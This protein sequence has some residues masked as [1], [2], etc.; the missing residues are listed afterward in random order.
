MDEPLIE[1]L[2]EASRR[3]TPP[4]EGELRVEGLTGAVEVIR[5]RWGVPHIYARELRDLYFAQGLV[6]GS[7]RLF[8]LDL[9]FRLG[10]GR[11]SELLGSLGLPFDRFARTVGWNRAARRAVE[12]YDDLSLDT[13]EAFAAGVRAW[14]ERM[15]APPVEYR[16][17]DLEP[18]H[19]DEGEA[20]FVG[21]SAAAFMAWGLSRNWDNELLRAEI[22]ER[23]GVEVM[24]TLFPDL[25]PESAV[26]TA[27]EGPDPLSLLT[28]APLPPSGQGSNNWVVSGSRT[29]TGKP[30]LANDPHLLVQ[31]PSIWFECHLVGPGIDVAGVSLPFSPGVVIGHND[32]IAWGFTNTEGD[33]QDLYL[34]RLS[35]DGRRAEFEGSWEPLR[36]HREEIRVR[37]LDQPEMVEVMESR[38][39]PLLDSYLVGVSEPTVV[40]GGIGRS[41]ALRWA[42]AEALIQPSTIH[43]MNAARNWEEFRQ[44]VRGWTCPGQNMVYADVDGNIGYQAT[45]LYP[46]RGNGDG[47]MP[48]PGWTGRHEWEGWIPFDELPRAFNP[49]RG[50]LLTANNKVY[51]DAYPHN[52]GRDFLPPHRARRIAELLTESDR[53]DRTSF[54][55]IQRDT[56][57]L[58]ARRLVPLLLR[59]EPGTDRHKQAMALLTEW[60]H[61]LGAGSAAAALY[62]VWVKHIAMRVLPPVLQDEALYTH[63]Y[64]RRQ[65]TNAFHHLVLP[66]LL[67]YPTAR[68]FGRDGVEARDEVLR[69]SLDD[70]LDELTA[71]LGEDMAEWRWGALHRVRFAGP[72]ARIPDLAPLFTAA[73]VEVGGDEQTVNQAMFEPG[74][75]YDA[76]VVPSWRQILDPS[77]WDASVGTHTTG[78]SGHPASPHYADLV[79]LW[80]AGEHHPMPFSRRAVEDAAEGTL[81]LLPS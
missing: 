57:S 13:A 26:V 79:E 54:A 76:M 80:A 53:H 75:S 59:I 66:N 27:G 62:E 32:R 64:A 71:A 18:L 48:V 15:K 31:L 42:G 12:G 39:G 46:I 55:R 2:R 73:E 19:I 69:A 52:L 61:D 22:A 9:M 7:E 43:R 77:D 63:F 6:V 44:A 41:Y 1:T 17:L 10:A 8:Q 3:A 11:L 38:H 4:I 33:V 5:D 23:A 68:W 35:D 58:S 16:F 78:Q 45:G 72:L 50:F 36:V 67:A 60:D 14:T 51:D 74:W 47:T 20:A 40:Q 70:A 24:R 49:D 81:R 25:A 28:Q 21:A 65:W 56:V 37:G 34:E 30:L 29:V